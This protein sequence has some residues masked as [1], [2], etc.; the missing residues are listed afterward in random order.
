[1]E[2]LKVHSGRYRLYCL[3]HET[4]PGFTQYPGSP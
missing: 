2:T 3:A 1:M 4:V